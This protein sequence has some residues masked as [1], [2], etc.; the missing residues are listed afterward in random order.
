M[1]VISLNFHKNPQFILIFEILI[2]QLL[3]ARFFFGTL[4]T[5]LVQR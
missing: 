4:P 3:T 1:I 2:K 5:Q